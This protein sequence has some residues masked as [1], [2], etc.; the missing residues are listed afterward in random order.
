MCVFVIL[1]V[2]VFTWSSLRDILR[3]S[4]LLDN[5]DYFIGRLVK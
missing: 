4:D 2:I 5:Q 3:I 1:C